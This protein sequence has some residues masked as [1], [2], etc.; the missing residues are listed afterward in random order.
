[1]AEEVLA[2]ELKNIAG[3]KCGGLLGERWSAWIDL[4]VIVVALFVFFHSEDCSVSV[5]S[6]L[7]M[8]PF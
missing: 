2:A 6:V 8:L 3:P 4:T 1:M 7:L 5:A